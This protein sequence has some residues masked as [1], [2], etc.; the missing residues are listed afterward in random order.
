LPFGADVARA[1][2]GCVESRWLLVSPFLRGQ[3]R[4]VDFVEAVNDDG[5]RFRHPGVVRQ[6]V[7][8]GDDRAV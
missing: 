5:A 8:L 4:D 6:V 3:E 7:D 1:S 2:S